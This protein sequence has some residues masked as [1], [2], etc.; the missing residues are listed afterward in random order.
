MSKQIECAKRNRAAVV[1]LMLLGV[2]ALSRVSLQAQNTIVSGV[3][4]NASGTPVEGAMVRV[5]STDL[6][7]TFLVVSQAQGRYA[8]PNLL[9]GKYS[10]EA[11]GGGYQSNPSEPM[12]VASGRQGRMDVALTVAQ[13][14]TPPEKRMTNADYEAMMPAGDAKQLIAS[15]CVLC[16]G[17]ERIVPTR[18]TRDEWQKIVTTMRSYLQDRRVLLSDQER[19]RIVNYVA[20]NFGP[21]VPRL[22]RAGGPADPNKH[23]PR[24]FLQGAEA[25]Y[26]AMEFNLK[27]GAGPHD[28]TVDSQGVAWVSERGSASF[29]R[30]DPK[31]LSYSLIATPLAKSPN[32]ALNAIATDPRD[33][34]WAMDNGPSAQLVQ[35]NTR[36]REFNLFP[37]PTP[38]NSGGSAINTLR[39][40]P[41][42][43]VWGT[44]IVSSRIVKLEPA[45]R[46]VTEFP[47]PKGS[48]P[49]GLAIGG[50]Q[51][52][53]YVANYGDEIVKLD[54]KT[55]KLAQYKVP[56]QLSDLR[57]MQADADG[58]LWAGGHESGKLVKVD[59]RT[60]TVTEYA[61]PTPGSG[62]YSVDVDR[63]RNLIWFGERYAD[64]IGRFD[65]RSNAWAEFPLPSSE[66]DVRR[67]EVDPSNPNRIWWSGNG[68]H[69]IGYVE[70]LE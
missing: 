29:G 43:S 2:I 7:L 23:L 9:P 27:R 11:F 19:D 57:R 33:M 10:V 55:G 26:V 8:T 59:Y 50:D 1:L 17:L 22:P 32:V 15:R 36:S 38:P 13:K 54:P 61:T 42:G 40:D 62:P 63:K 16:H 21:D 64:K 65:P 48:H 56:T 58:N 39:F 31:S 37:I 53:W 6:G 67:I 69:K 52:I 4:K 70:V 28:I 25:K 68:S 60:G 34:V 12:E 20:T 3:V 46:K 66:T 49:Y 5:R 45:T 41:D 24:N 18:E 30:L 51:M 35:Y 44:G 47:V 14:V